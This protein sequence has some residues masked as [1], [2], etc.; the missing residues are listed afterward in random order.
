MH[1][2]AAAPPEDLFAPLL[3]A[4]LAPVAHPGFWEAAAAPP[5]A[6]RQMLGSSGGAAGDG[7][8]SAAEGPAAEHALLAEEVLMLK[9][10]AAR[11]ARMTRG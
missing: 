9:R 6:L 7:D 2:S 3:D 5:D 8:V 1:I 4:A 10:A 11:L